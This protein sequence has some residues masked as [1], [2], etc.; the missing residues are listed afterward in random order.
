MKIFSISILISLL[1]ISCSSKK[2]L[3]YIE[4]ADKINEWSLKKKGISLNK[5]QIGDVLNIIVKSKSFEAAIIY[6][7]LALKTDY[8]A[9]ITSLLEISGYRVDENH[10]INFPVLGLVSTNNLTSV[11]LEK[12]LELILIN[13]NHLLDAMVSV[14]IVNS[15]FTILGEVNLP[16]TFINY[17]ENLNIFQALGYAG[18]LTIDGR[19]N[20]ITLLRTTNGLKKVLK[21]DL[22]D[23]KFLNKS[24]FYI[25]SNDVIIVNP[26]FSKVKSAGFIGSPSSLASM[27][28]IFLSI[29]LLII[30]K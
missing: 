4:G 21:I 20:N 8:S 6:N 1:L 27:A 5:I 29:T 15:R 11:E 22:T 19:R 23:P 10:M 24:E 7:N 13:E 16:G 2:D 12:S 17:K 9:P 25:K 3:V 28:S 30:N 14:N 26:S 18:D